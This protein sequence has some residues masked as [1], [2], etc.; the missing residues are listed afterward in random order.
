MK[1]LI[2]ELDAVSVAHRFDKIAAE[3]KRKDC[4]EGGVSTGPAQGKTI[5]RTGLDRDAAR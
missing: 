3:G 5:I 4:L 1:R 2:G